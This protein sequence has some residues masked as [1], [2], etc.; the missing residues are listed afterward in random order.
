MQETLVIIDG[1]SLINRAFYA[2]PLLSNSRGEFSNGVYGFANILIKTIIENNPNYVVVALDYGKKTFRNQLYVDYK[3]KR[4]PTPEELKSQFPIL[5]DMLTA[6]GIAYIEKEGFEAD[7]IIG[8]LSKKFDTKNIVITGDKDSLQLIDKNT[9][10]WL[11]KKGITEIKL[12]NETSLKEEY[13]LEP[14]QIIELKALMGDSSDNIPGVAGVGEKTALS[15][16][17][18]YKDLNGVYTN[19]DGIKGKL[20]EKLINSKEDAYLSQE[21]ATIKLD[22]PLKETLED[23]KYSFPFSKEVLEFFKRY[24]FNSLLKKEGLFEGNIQAPSFQKYSANIIEIKDEKTLNKQIKHIKN[25]N[26]FYFDI[27][28]VGLSFA[29]DKNCQFICKY[30]VDLLDTSLNIDI[31]INK[32]KDIFEDETIE[33]CVYDKKGLMHILDKYQIKLQGVK[34]D[35]LLG[36][37]LLSAGERETSKQNLFSMYALEKEYNAVNLFY[38]YEKLVEDLKENNLNDLYYN[39]EFPLIEVLYYMEKMGFKVNKETLNELGERYTLEI[40]EIANTIKRLAGEDFNINSPKQ[41]SVILFDKLGLICANNKKKSTSIEYLEQMYDLHPIIPAIIRYRKLQKI[42]ATY[43]EPYKELIKDNNDIINTIFNQTLTAT[44]RLSSSEPNLQNIP[45]RDDEGKGLRK[46]FITRYNDGALVGADYSQIELRLLAHMSK[47]ETLIQAFNNNI[48]IHALTASEV[49]GVDIQEVTPFMRR[50]AKAV[51]F[52]IIY[53]IS[54][55]GLAQNI[56][57]KIYEAKEYIERYFLRYPSIKQFMQNNIDIAK[58]TGYAT[59]IF[60]RRRKINELFVPRT[61]MFGERVAMNMPLQGSASDIIKLAMVNVFKA[62]KENNL[63]SK[64]IL[65]VHDELIIDCPQDEITTVAKILKD[66]MENVV[67]L[68]VPLSVDVNSGKT[69]YDC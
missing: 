68:S 22:V 26:K 67:K 29:Y 23:F 19:I 45:V 46:I 12:M 31:A 48:D 40:E 56:N 38:A 7:D 15:L 49:F 42:L 25:A 65:Q 39:I 36:Y 3:G 21:L 58:R 50:T 37:Y 28:E 60:N 6:M 43:I 53:G 44:G 18:Q 33:K 54:E 1:N 62:L 2:L 17:E 24:E 34:F 5:K 9:E 41:L 64:L 59:S 63:K 47:D 66:N 14:W 16:L 20:Q 10:V 13:N 32:L 69:W 52:G 4:K 55:Y 30:P 8:T 61:R 35:C 51:N 11:T 27:D 57:C